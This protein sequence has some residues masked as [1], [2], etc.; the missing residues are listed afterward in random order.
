VNG[1]LVILRRELGSYFNSPMAYIVAM[2]FMLLN[3]SLYVLDL[4]MVNQVSM[5]GFFEWLSWS[6]CFVIPAITMRLWAE[7]K[8]SSTYELLL[9]FP[10]RG[11]ALVA[12]KFLAACVFYVF[13]LSGSL[14]IPVALQTLSTPG[15]GP[16]W[17]AIGAA[18]LGTI[19]CGALLIAL[20]IFISGLCRDQI[21]AFILTLVAVLG[22]R[23]VGFTPVAGQI[24]SVLPGAG[25]FLR[26]SVS[27]S[28]PLGRFARGLVDVGDVLYFLAWTVVFLGLNAVNLEGRLRPGSKLRHGL[29]VALGVPVAVLLGSLVMGAGPRFDLTADK[30]YTVSEAAGEVL[31]GIPEDRPVRIKLYFS[32]KEEMPTAMATLERD[33]LEKIEELQRRARGRLVVET[34]HLHA[35]DAILRAIQEAREASL[36][37]KKDEEGMDGDE[38]ERGAVEEKLLQEGVAPFRVRTGGLTGSE[39]KVVYASLAL[40]Y[41]ASK[42]EVIPQLSPGFLGSMEQELITRIHRLVT[43]KKPVVALMAPIERVDIPPQQMNLMMQLGIPLD[44]LAREQDDYRTVRALLAQ[45]EQYDV[46]RLRPES[47]EPL[48][49]DVSTLIL[50][51]PESLSERMAWEVARLLHRGGSVIIA[52]QAFDSS[53]RPT[54]GGAALQLQRVTT[55]LDP[56]LQRYGLSVPA[57]MVVNETSFP[58]TYGMGFLGQGITV[59]FRWIFRLDAANFDR[60][61][62]LTNGVGGDFMLIE[63]SSPVKVDEAKAAELKLDVKRV[64]ATGR[65]AWTREVPEFQVPED[66]NEVKESAGPVTMAALVRGQFPAPEETPPA[67]PPEPGQEDAPPPEPQAP[68]EAKPGSLF[69]L[70]TARPFHDEA[71]VDQSG[72]ISWAG[73]LLK[74]AVDALSLGDVL[75]RLTLREPT[76]RPIKDVDRAT[77]VLYQFV[78]VG[79]APAIY[80]VI[81]VLRLVARRRAQERGV[82]RAAAAVAAGGAS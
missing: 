35:D 78:I 49:D 44:Q 75:L 34:V 50:V 26:E 15:L 71:L 56:L 64:L 72:Q 51:R 42:K 31:S 61:T 41:G 11:V 1:A 76:P 55:G 69:V 29:A 60:S 43:E 53:L 62:S 17:G 63:A 9:T 21:E 14:V 22:L 37:K 33:V 36:G 30:V 24:E 32:P 47:T 65:D 79:L 2:G 59:D 6:A 19:L 3:A 82:A 16:E 54:R 5:R 38:K 58:V 77:V 74:N 46:R 80:L 8:R 81:G 70:G 39:T 67:W 12:G 10:M 23:L 18:Y 48:G 25:N 52:A 68:V 28:G 4:W 73:Q 20:G 7:E 13:C 27:F 45:A 57:E 66:I 40:T